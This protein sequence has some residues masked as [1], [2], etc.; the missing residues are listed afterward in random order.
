MWDLWWTKW[1]RDRFFSRLYRFPSVSIITPMLRTD[2]HLRTALTRRTNVRSLGHFPKATLFRKSGSTGLK[3]LSVNHSPISYKSLQ[4][5]VSYAQLLTWSTVFSTTT[6]TVVKTVPT[7][8]TSPAYDMTQCYYLDACRSGSRARPFA[9]WADLRHIGP[10]AYGGAKL[11][12]DSRIR[13]F[14][15]YAM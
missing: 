9:D 15:K 1:H 5:F 14:K 3:V 10:R 13:N 2:L 8:T 4:Y 7:D 12:R 6:I 11:I